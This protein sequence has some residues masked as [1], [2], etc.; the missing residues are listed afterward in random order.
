MKKIKSLISEITVVDI[1]LASA[2]CL[3]GAFLIINLSK[4]FL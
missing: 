2:L 4:L 3:Y 1:V